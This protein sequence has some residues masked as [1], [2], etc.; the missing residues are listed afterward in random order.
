M[1]CQIS[2][3]AFEYERSYSVHIHAQSRFQSMPVRVL[4]VGIALGKPNEICNFIG[5]REINESDIE[6][7][8]QREIS[9][10][11]MRGFVDNAKRCKQKTAME[12]FVNCVC[13]ILM[14]KILLTVV[15][16]NRCIVIIMN[17]Y[18]LL[19]T[20][21]NY[22]T[23]LYGINVSIMQRKARPP[24]SRVINRMSNALE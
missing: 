24:L 21:G 13:Y 14:F 20:F 2:F 7:K 12:S 19:E 15:L 22:Y 23:E 4:V 9:A 3:E 10:G 11:I 18:S 16:C 17:L 6:S 5:C 8:R 1:N